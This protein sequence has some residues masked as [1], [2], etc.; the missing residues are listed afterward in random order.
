VTRTFRNTNGETH[1]VPDNVM[2]AAGQKLT[3]TL[4]EYRTQTSY[5]IG[6]GWVE[7]PPYYRLPTNHGAVVYS[8]DVNKSFVL[9]GGSWWHMQNSYSN[10]DLMYIY[11]DLVTKFEGFDA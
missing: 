2:V 3:Q 1:T 11:H 6:D 10:E 4:L 9:M 7:E 5:L 8:P